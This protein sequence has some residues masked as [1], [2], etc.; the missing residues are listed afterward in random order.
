M[1]RIT[2]PEFWT[3]VPFSG[4]GPCQRKHLFEAALFMACQR[5]KGAMKI[6]S[7]FCPC[8]KCPDGKSCLSCGSFSLASEAAARGRRVSAGF[9]GG[10]I[11]TF[12]IHPIR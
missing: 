1:K 3:G 10:A 5:K 4:S 2:F 9:K 6:L 11:S 7:E 12:Y 8:V